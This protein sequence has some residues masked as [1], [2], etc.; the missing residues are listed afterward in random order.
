MVEPG[1]R[2]LLQGPN[3]EGKS[4]LLYLLSGQYR[5]DS[6]RI[7]YGSTPTAELSLKALREKYRLI[8]QENDL[9][10]C[11][12]PRNIELSGEPDREACRETLGKLRMEDR[13]E[14]EASR[15]SQ[16]EKQRVNIARALRRGGDGEIFLLGDEIT[17]NIDPENAANIFRLLQEEFAHS[18]IILVAVFAGMA[19]VDLAVLNDHELDLNTSMMYRTEDYQTAIEL[20]NSGKVQLKPLISQRFP[21][22]QY[23][24]AYQYIDA[25]RE[26]TMKVLIDVQK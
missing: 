8:A 7:L 14:R 11:D 21:F 19:K 16:G 5:P 1:E 9:F 6:G 3:G 24:D 10:H 18:T 13:L 15:L 23:L 2:V 26:T 4:T 22:R 17:A 12:V 25:N 20:A